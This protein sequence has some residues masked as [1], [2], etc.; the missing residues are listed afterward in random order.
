[1][2]HNGWKRTVEDQDPIPE[3]IRGKLPQPGGKRRGFH[4]HAGSEGRLLS[5]NSFTATWFGNRPEEMIGLR[6]RASF[7]PQSPSVKLEIVQTV[8]RNGKSVRDEF[9]LKVGR[10]NLDQRQLHALEK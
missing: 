3:T 10:G 5:V 6:A 8:F 1:V 2:V 4:F 7:R 9:E